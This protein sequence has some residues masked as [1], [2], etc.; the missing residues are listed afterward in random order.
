MHPSPWDM[1]FGSQNVHF[2]VRNM[3]PSPWDMHF[4]SRNV[5]FSLR[6][7]HPSSWD[8]HF[9]SQN[10]HFS[11]RN[12]HPSSWDMHFSSQNVHFNDK[13]GGFRK[14]KDCK[15][16]FFYKSISSFRFSF[17]SRKSGYCSAILSKRCLLLSCLWI[18]TIS[19]SP[20]FT[21]KLKAIN[22]LW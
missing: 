6:N 21:M 13:E 17:S 7:M 19:F 16:S 5:H 12:M 10:V 15:S 22:L 18:G 8:M 14:G 1:H 4:S 2:C 20:S 9:G 3:H 11:L